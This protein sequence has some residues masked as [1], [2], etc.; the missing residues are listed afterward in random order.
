V[1][2]YL[3]AQDRRDER[4]RHALE[5]EHGQFLSDLRQRMDARRRARTRAA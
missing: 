4:L 5:A 1:D 2:A 3:Q